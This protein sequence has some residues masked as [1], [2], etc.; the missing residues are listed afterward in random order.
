MTLY[1][2]TPGRRATQVLSDVFVLGWV[3]LWIYLG[4]Y[5]HA[6]V[7][8]MLSPARRLESS[9]TSLSRTMSD[10]ASTVR[11]VPLLGDTLRA[12]LEQ[13]AGAGASMTSAGRDLA[14][15]VQRLADVLGIL[16][17]V[18]PIALVVAGWLF[19]RGRF[20]RRAGAAQQLLDSDAD[21]DLFALRAM[22]R[23]PLP[24]LARISDD[25]AGAWRRGDAQVIRAL[26]LLELSDSGLRPPTP[27]PVTR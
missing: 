16:T 24:R 4:R 22:S 3:V 23:Q 27:I 2:Q 7:L 11:D 20:V 10:A 8:T 17:A 18:V 13:A 26:A 25:P 19:L 15:T 12:P 1:A 21:L 5:V 14:A 9:G 6:A